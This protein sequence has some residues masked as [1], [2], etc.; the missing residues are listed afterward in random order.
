MRVQVSLETCQGIGLCELH[1]PATFEV[2]EGG[3]A[4]VVQADVPAEQQEAVRTAAARCPTES[5]VIIE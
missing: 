4:V 3:Y 1:V 5:I 2:C